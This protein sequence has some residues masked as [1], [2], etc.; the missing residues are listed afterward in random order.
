[1]FRCEVTGNQSKEGEKPQRL[2]VEMRSRQYRHWNREAEEEW[3]SNGFE[4]VREINV[5]AE[6]VSIWNSWNDEDRAAFL[7]NF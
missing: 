4:I 6:G 3:F 5:S 1:M 7:K 2:V